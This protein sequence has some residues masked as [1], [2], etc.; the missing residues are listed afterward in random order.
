LRTFPA[1]RGAGAVAV[2]FAMSAAP[3]LEGPEVM[4]AGVPAG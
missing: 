3:Q 4:T 1:G 2:S